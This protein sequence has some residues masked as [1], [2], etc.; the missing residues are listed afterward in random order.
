MQSKSVRGM[1]LE[2]SLWSLF[3]TLMDVLSI[4]MKK[5]SCQRNLHR[6][7]LFI[8]LPVDFLEENNV[9]LRAYREPRRTNVLYRL[10]SFLVDDKSLYDLN[11]ETP[12]GLYT[13]SVV[14]RRR[15]SSRLVLQFFFTSLQAV[16]SY[17]LAERQA[18]LGSH[19]HHL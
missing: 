1:P 2:T 15:F 9:S 12:L 6:R 13:R 7:F 4:P 14:Q 8:I 11:A 3:E 18:N 16:R 19:T 10:D 5:Y 17:G